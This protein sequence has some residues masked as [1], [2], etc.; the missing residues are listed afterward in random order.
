MHAYLADA[1]A[2]ARIADLHREADAAR[3]AAGVPRTSRPNIWAGWGA[4]FASWVE[5]PRAGRSV[6]VCCP[7]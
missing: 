7:A 4:R 2:A 5:R 6:G 3:V 1:F